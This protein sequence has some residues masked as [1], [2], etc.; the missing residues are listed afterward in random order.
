MANHLDQM[1]R[2]CMSP[3]QGDVMVG[4]KYYERI[5]SQNRNK[6]V[7]LVSYGFLQT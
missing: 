4:S 2:T 1:L 6:T 3:L 5:L 7:A